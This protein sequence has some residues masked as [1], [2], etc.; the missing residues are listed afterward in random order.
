MLSYIVYAITNALI[1]PML[2]FFYPETARASSF[3]L[4]LLSY[5]KPASVELSY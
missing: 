3:L 4:S 2:Y 5:R 1:V